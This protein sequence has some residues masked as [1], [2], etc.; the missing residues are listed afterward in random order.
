MKEKGFS[1]SEI[2][3]IKIFYKNNTTKENL[4]KNSS[5]LTSTIFKNHIQDFLNRS[6]RRISFPS[7]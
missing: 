2:D 6:T 4:L 3:E 7:L 1:D 5:N